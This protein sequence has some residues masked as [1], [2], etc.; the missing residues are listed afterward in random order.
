MT[1][2]PPSRGALLR[3]GGY[4]G[5]DV[6]VLPVFQFSMPMKHGEVLGVGW[7]FGVKEF[8][9]MEFG[10]FRRFGRF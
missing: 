1:T 4:G 5:Q 6:K 10:R 2:H 8:G 7:E 3:T 9:V